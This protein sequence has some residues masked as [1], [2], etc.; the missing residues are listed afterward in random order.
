MNKTIQNKDVF[1]T[2]EMELI[3]IIKEDL[4]RGQGTIGDVVDMMF[5]KHIEEGDRIRTVTV[6]IDE[7][8]M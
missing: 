7:E 4:V 1:G 6:H 2:V 3:T 5:S 8:R